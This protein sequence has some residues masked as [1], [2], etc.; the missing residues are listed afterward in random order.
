MSKNFT[1][2]RLDQVIGDKRL[3]VFDNYGVDAE[4][5][6]YAVKRGTE[7]FKL[8][9]KYFAAN[10][11]EPEGNL[12]DKMCCE[13]WTSTK[14]DGTLGSAYS[15]GRLEAHQE[16]SWDSENGIRLVVPLSEIQDDI[17]DSYTVSGKNGDVTVVTYGEYPQT[18]I[19]GDE[20]K[21]LTEL[22]EDGV[23]KPTGKS[24]GAEGY[25]V[26]RYYDGN[27]WKYEESDY[28]E[29]ELDGERYVLAERAVWD[30]G[31]SNRYFWSKVEPVEWL[32]DEKSGLAISKKC[33]VG[34][35]P[36]KRN[37]LY[38]GNI[39]KTRVQSFIDNNLVYDLMSQEKSL[40]K[41]M[42][43]GFSTEDDLAQVFDD[44]EIEIAET[45]ERSLH[46]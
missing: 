9:G 4:V 40:K 3:E 34:G 15:V 1:I 44:E 45:K 10:G 38:L 12:L 37:G 7:G 29:Y 24:Y 6:D 19:I 20:S 43:E 42:D 21:K 18:V 16:A 23:M 8:K 30:N 35:I 25:N 27:K 5:T 33:I 11:M 2:L 22:Y 31:D 17:I 28:Q 26:E 36:L 32:V 13:Y 41:E 46:K 39:N 14:A